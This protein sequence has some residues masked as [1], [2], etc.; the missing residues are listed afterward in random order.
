LVVVEVGWEGVDEAGAAESP[1]TLNGVVQ[2]GVADLAVVEQP[3]GFLHIRYIRF[4]QRCCSPCSACSPCWGKVPR[5][6]V[7]QILSLVPLKHGGADAHVARCDVVFPE[8]AG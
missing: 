7:C 5:P 8:P 1:L 3:V 4:I 2:I 6:G